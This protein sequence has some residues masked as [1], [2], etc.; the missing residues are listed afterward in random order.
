[1]KKHF[2]CIKILFFLNLLSFSNIFAQQVGN[3]AFLK[4]QYLEVGIAKSGSFGTEGIAPSGYNA[5]VN[6]RLGF[7]ADPARDGFNVGSPSYTGDFFLP[8]SPEEG[9]G[10]TINGADYF[11]GTRVSRQDIAGSIV[12][13]SNT[14]TDVSATWTGNINGL[15]ITQTVSFPKNALYFIIQVKIKNTSTS[16][17]PGIY[18]MRNVDPDNEER[19]GGGYST[20]NSIIQ[21]PPNSNCNTGLVEA[22]GTNFGMY[23]GLGTKDDRAK[24]TF[25]GFANRSASNIWNGVSLSQSGSLTADQAISIAYNIGNLAPEQETKLTYAYVLGQDE[26][27]DALDATAEAKFFAGEVDIT[28]EDSYTNCPGNPV[29]LSVS[30]INNYTWTW[31]GGDLSPTS[32]SSV[33]VN[34][35]SNTVYTVVG[36]PISS[37]STCGFGTITRSIT[38]NVMDEIEPQVFTKPI[39][40]TLD[41][42]GSASITGSDINDESNDTCGI[43]SIVASKTSF[44]CS[45]I[46][47]NTVSLTVTDTNGNIASADAIVTVEDTSAPSIVLNGDA[48]VTHEAFTTYTDLGATTADNC[49]T[50]LVS[51]NDVD[52]NIPGSYTVTYT[53]TDASGN[54]T[55]KTR[56]VVVQDVTVPIAMAKDITVQLDASGNASIV[57]GDIDNGSSDNSGEVTLSI[58]ENTFGCENLET[59]SSL[60]FDGDNDIISLSK[61]LSIGQGNSTVEAWIKVPKIGSGGL[62]ASERVGI[63]LGNYPSSR[64]LGYELYNQGQ[65]RWWWNNGQIDVRGTRDLRDDKWHH[66]A[67]VRIASENRFIAYID[68][69]IEFN[70]VKSSSSFNMT[71]APKIGGDNRSNP[72]NFH[73]NIDE[74]SVWNVA[75]T[76]TEIQSDLKNRLNGNEPNLSNYWNFNEASGT[77]LQDIASNN[78]NNGTLVSMDASSDWVNGVSNIVVLKATDPSGNSSTT[79]ARIIVEDTIAPETKVNDITVQLDANGNASITAAQLDN[80]SND[81]C[82]IASI[83]ASKTSFDCSNIGANTVSLTVTD[84]NGNV[85]SADAIVTVEDATAPV[86]I[87]QDITV[88]LD[89][90]GV[91]SIL[92]S[93]IDNGSND[94]CGVTLALSKVEFDCSNVG[95]NTVT[96]TVTDANENVSTI[97]AIVTVED[98]TAPTAIAQDITVQLDANGVA[99]ILP[100]DIDNGSND[101][102]GITLTLSKLDFD[103]SNVGANTVTLSVTD[104]N[105]NV[106]TIDAV[107]TVEDTIAPVAIAQDLTLVLDANGNASITAAQLDNGSNDACGIAS[108]VA[109]KTSFDCSNAGLNTVSLTVTDINGNVASVDATVTV[110]DTID[111][112]AI[113]QNISIDLDATGNATIT[114]E[115]IDNGSS[116][117]CSFTTSLDMVNFTCAN[118]GIENT[119]TLTVTD[120]SGNSASTTATVTVNDVTL[121]T[122]LTQPITVSLDENGEGTTTAEAINNGSNDACGIASIAIDIASFDCS[123][124]GENT[125]TLTVTDN[126][127][128]IASEQ[129]IV[130]VVDTIAPIVGTRNI[131]VE[132]DANGAATITPEDVLLLTEDDVERGDQ[133]T[134][135]AA[136]YHAMYLSNYGYANNYYKADA[137]EENDAILKN[138]DIVEYD[139]N[140]A[141]HHRRNARF[142]FDENQGS[143]IKNL[144]GT[145]TVTGTL[146]NTMNSDDKWIVTLN[147]E[148]ARNWTE[149]SALGR[150][151][152]GNRWRTRSKYKDWMYYE[153]ATGSKITGAGINEGKETMIYHAPSNK[154]YGFQVG[155]GANLQN[156]NL[157]LSGWFYYKNRRGRWA[158]G[159]F[160]LNITDCD[161]LPIPDGTILT[162]DNCSIESYALDVDTF[163]CDDLGENIVQVSVTDQSGNTTTKPVT[164]TVLGDKPEVRIQDF[165]LAYGQKKNTIFLGYEESVH[166]CPV[167]TGGDGFTYQWTDESGTV[168]STKKLPKVSPKFTTTYTLTVTNSNGCATSA[169]IEVCVIDARAN[170]NQYR[171]NERHGYHGYYDKV[172]ICIPQRKNGT[173]TYKEINVKKSYV[174]YY[175]KRGATL[176]GCN[177]TCVNEDDIVIEPVVELSL[178]PNPSSGIFNVEVKNLQKDATVL[179][180]NMYGRVI[181]RKYIRVRYGQNKVQMG[182]HRLREGAY[183]VKVL[184][185]GNIFTKTMLIQRTRH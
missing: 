168:V 159:D 46:G 162:S 17:V 36:N 161:K 75:K 149:W 142:I 104:A 41:E 141:R 137:K 112:V 185:D 72:P 174:K 133:C 165:T 24:V 34:P 20:R 16:T 59:N 18:Y 126:N 80:G 77:S 155:D 143:L 76:Q 48:S 38:V 176:G 9:W 117:N 84:I 140:Q 110:E 57:A 179:L 109:S 69:E 55:T 134:V 99:S 158:Q 118:I 88:Q 95:A 54:E 153:M 96:L 138:E 171:Y 116:D 156:A 139:D 108:I 113:A 107:V 87:A 61:P 169:S 180:Y 63:I 94:A 28:S 151:Y 45:N 64:N 44:D 157:G 70:I 93:D 12:N 111:P 50:T 32:G 181:Q 60:N 13:Y 164:I 184:T 129:A 8:G 127:G 135:S 26:L 97:D 85:A 102:C 81:A 47:A 15:E 120:A 74:L 11:N 172:K 56:T 136:K 10:L 131:S 53:A 100:S 43:A 115:M 166:L 22:V 68:G 92:P 121:P 31:S 182:Y 145:A 35:E 58:N 23:L 21:Q 119:V 130:T 66:V 122:V 4:G 3:D 42:N 25:G 86:A 91:A 98:A 27:T 29:T 173:I 65:I 52:E 67:F 33:I 49:S 30:N 39:T 62:Q 144:D 83:V 51:S 177:A 147:L 106:S 124:L 114:P 105:A 103:C 78:D 37:S 19:W 146:V 7:V 150:R 89:A 71:A 178:Y 148:N 6:G 90:N 125:V 175:L 14:A 40:I 1:M 82:G 163:G 160:N 73:G 128:N 5:N 154:R 183:I 2:I 123:N 79:T 170:N 167:V 132:L 101:A 152:K